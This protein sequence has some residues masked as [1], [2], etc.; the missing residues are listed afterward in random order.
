MHVLR[1]R[2]RRA[3]FTVATVL[4]AGAVLRIEGQGTPPPADVATALARAGSASA[5]DLTTLA[6]GRVVTHT[7]VVPETLETSVVA[8]V[9]INTGLD[10][11][12]AYF[13]QLLSYVD[14][15]TTLHYAPLKW[16]AEDADFAGAT[17][18]APDLADLRSCAPARCDIRVGAATAESI[19]ATDWTSGD[20][21]ERANR[22]LRR[23]LTAAVNAY[24]RSGDAGL[25][26]YD[27][28]G[29]PLDL[30]ALWR[31]LEDASPIPAALSPSLQRYLER[32]PD[33]MPAEAS[34]EF[35]VDSQHLTGL[36]TV[37]GV[38][39]LITWR[40]SAQPQRVIVVQKQIAATHYFFGS[41][42]VTL[43]VQDAATP[44]ATY[45]VYTNRARGD[46]LRGAQP[47]QTGLRG[48][49]STIGASVQRRLGEQLVKQ[50]AERLMTSMK[51]ALEQ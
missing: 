38:T 2:G 34:N 41:M 1:C 35:Y 18:D 37:L 16:P 42:A 22:W 49:I 29:M 12:L 11:T 6:A 45:V 3:G 5:D 7:Q 39:H 13:R 24:Q 50:S 28:R 48:R 17:L 47:T 36:K 33:A 21:A 30:P 27:D 31:Q 32:F 51:S 43:F 44:P 4:I 15:Q 23:E 25:R 26:S 14:G 10:R 40:D 20:A 9:K 8:A 19:Q 46:L